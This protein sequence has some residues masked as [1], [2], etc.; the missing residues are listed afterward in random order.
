[1][2]VWR[3][4]QTAAREAAGVAVARGVHLPYP[5]P[6]VA[7]EA[8]ASQTASHNSPMLQDVRRGAPTEIEYINGAVVRE[9]EKIGV[10]S[11]VNRALM[12]LVKA[13]KPG[14]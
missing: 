1:M 2:C 6:V 4:M 14:G 8:I 13:L 5:D 10:A 3:A 12:L 11:P 9:G 7:C